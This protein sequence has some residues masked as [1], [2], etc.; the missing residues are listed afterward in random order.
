MQDLLSERLRAEFGEMQPIYIDGVAG[1]LNL[2]DNFATY[3]F[4]WVASIQSGAVCRQP[5]LVLI[6]PRK[7]MLCRKDCMVERT[8]DCQKRPHIERVQT[9]Q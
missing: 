6:R 7:S 4:R 3:Y 5:A 8:L 1:L 2:G 9:V